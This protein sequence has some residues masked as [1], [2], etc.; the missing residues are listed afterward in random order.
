MSARIQTKR[1]VGLGLLLGMVSFWMLFGFER[2][3]GIAPSYTWPMG[4]QAQHI[5]GAYAYLDGK[6][7]FPLFTTDRINQPAGVNI[8]FTDSAPFAGLLA[9]LL[10][11]LTGIRFN[12]L[13]AWFCILWIGQA[14][15]GAYLFKQ[16]CPRH[17]VMYVC[18]A[19]FALAWPAF[20]I[21]HFHFGR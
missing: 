13:G 5:A 11:S 19:M 15:A 10:Y 20:L 9:K 3:V 14:T 6:W 7:G 16:F 17:P 4:D 18:G 21:R 1:A 8:I 2:A 12:Y